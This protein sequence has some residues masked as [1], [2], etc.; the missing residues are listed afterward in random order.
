MVYSTKDGET[1]SFIKETQFV[2]KCVNCGIELVSDSSCDQCGFIQMS[3]Q[4]NNPM[5][6]CE[7]CLNDID[8]ALGK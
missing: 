5:C 6:D 4:K 1:F 8:N 3:H 2:K 7:K